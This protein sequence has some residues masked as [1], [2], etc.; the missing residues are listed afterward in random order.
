MIW[1]DNYNEKIIRKTKMLL[2]KILTWYKEKQWRGT[3]TK[4]TW[5]TVNQ[6]ENVRYKPNYI[7]N[8]IKCEWIKQYSHNLNFIK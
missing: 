2:W 3:E 7:Y 4:M 5:D 1:I 6:G 8:G